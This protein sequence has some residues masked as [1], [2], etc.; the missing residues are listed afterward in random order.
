MKTKVVYVIVSSDKDLYLEQAFLSVYS[1][2][3]YSPDTSVE[4]VVDKE[5][6]QTLYEKRTN[7][8]RY[9]TKKIVVDVPAKYKRAYASRWIK[10]R[11]RKIVDG[12]F[13][14]VDSDTIITDD[15]KDIDYF[16][17]DIG[18]VL[19]LHGCFLSKEAKNNHLKWALRDGWTCADNV[20]YFNSG[21]MFVRDTEAAHHFYDI[22]H[23]KWCSGMERYNFLFDQSSLAA[24]NES[25]GMMIKELQGIW[26]CQLL[27]NGLPFLQH[28]KIV[29]HI[30]LQKTNRKSPWKFYDQKLYYSIKQTGSISIEIHDMLKNAKSQFDIPCKVIG[31]SEIKMLN[32]LGLRIL[33]KIGVV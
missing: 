4:L 27:Y 15:L 1:L 28:A 13:L 31:V 17:G 9:F 18:A 8:L 22:W 26:N 23:E 33:K 7:L 3:I 30:D 19:N 25:L 6:D 5:T 20:P 29:H 2:K 24:T 10:T 21:V 11:L 12:D 32:S 16:E 14:F